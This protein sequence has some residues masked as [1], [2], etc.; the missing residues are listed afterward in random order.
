MIYKKWGTRP[1]SVRSKRTWPGYASF[2]WVAVFI[3]FHIYWAFGGRFGLGDASN[4]IPPLPTNLSEWI[5]FYIVI[6][7]FAAGT[8][9]PLATV[10][11]WGRFIPRRIIYIACCIGC[12]VLILRGGAGFVDDFFRT[13]DLLPNGITGLTYE[14][15]YGDKHISTY[16]L[17]S[18]RAM[19]GN[20]FLGGILYGLAA[21]FY[22]SRI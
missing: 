8:I 21:W 15:I 20:F 7:M 17:W 9:A 3:L 10:Q 6:I 1:S 18:S 2:V 14:Q 5:Y 12:V 4:P 22:H 11:S 19:D 16:T 13:T